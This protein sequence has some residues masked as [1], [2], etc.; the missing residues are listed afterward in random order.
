MSQHYRCIAAA[1]LN[2]AAH[3]FVTADHAS[4]SHG[5]A[6]GFDGKISGPLDGTAITR[7]P[8][9]VWHSCGATSSAKVL[10]PAGAGGVGPGVPVEA[11]L[12]Q[13][14]VR[15]Y[16]ALESGVIAVIVTDLKAFSSSSREAALCLKSFEHRTRGEQG[17]LTPKS[18]QIKNQRQEPTRRCN[19]FRSAETTHEHPC[20][21]TDRASGAALNAGATS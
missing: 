15:S 14:S 10:Q 12:Q 1:A 2:V 3:R 19:G 11:D 9:D 20:Y 7:L 16:K 17:P 6:R 13:G 18:T 4:V 5:K 21:R 8:V